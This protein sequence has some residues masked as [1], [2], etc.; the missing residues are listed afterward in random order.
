MSSDETLKISF[1]VFLQ[2][3]NSASV[4]RRS[5]QTLA[6]EIY[7]VPHRIYPGIERGIQN[8]VKH[9]RWSLLRKWLMTESCFTKSSIWDIWQGFEYASEVMNEILRLLFQFPVTTCVKNLIFNLLMLHNWVNWDWLNE[10]ITGSYGGL[11]KLEV[12]FIA[13]GCLNSKI[14]HIIKYIIKYEMLGK[15]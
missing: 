14:Y 10:S 11:K 6:S 5:I 4:H 8:L 12:S 7:K 13:C 15:R 2:K 1:K 3:N 9:L